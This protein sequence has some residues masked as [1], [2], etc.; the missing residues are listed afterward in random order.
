[1]ILSSRA[2]QA[3][4]GIALVFVWS[5]AVAN[6]I[7]VQRDGSGDFSNLWDAVGVAVPGD[8]LLVGPGNY[9]ESQDFQHSYVATG[10]TF[11]GIAV[12]SLTVI[13]EEPNSTWI[14]PDV[15]NILGELPKG[16][17]LAP[18]ITGTRL[19]GLGV[20][21]VSEGFRLTG[22][23]YVEDATTSGCSL[24]ILALDSPH[25]VIQGGTLRGS[26]KAMVL[27]RCTS[28][29]VRDATFM[30]RS[31]LTALASDQIDVVDCTFKGSGLALDFEGSDN[32][33]VSRC[34]IEETSGAGVSFNDGSLGGEV[35]N[36]VIAAEQVGI[37]I[38]SYSCVV[39]TSSIVRNAN[40]ALVRL[41]GDSELTMTQSHLVPDESLAVRLSAYSLTPVP[42]FIDM[43]NNYWGGLDSSQIADLIHDGNDDPSLKGFVEYEPF[44]A[45]P[46]TSSTRSWSSF[47]TRH[48]TPKPR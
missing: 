22:R 31:G 18:D 29:L 37:D 30:E 36:T 32:C 43:T 33:R 12:D 10:E 7:H 34:S 39:V 3:W 25:G 35:H 1:M 5:Q 9:V 14:G 27:Y 44:S 41:S 38:D 11:F 4:L 6:T 19:I 28:V 21:N 46:L 45:V 20:R 40:F 23:F 24:G 26:T 47:K 15:P 2:G 42:I 16:I 8:T 17:A 48:R 13:A